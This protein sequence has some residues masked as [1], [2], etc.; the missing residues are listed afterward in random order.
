MGPE[1]AVLGLSGGCLG[2]CL[3]GCCCGGHLG[4][5]LV[6]DW[7]TMGGDRRPPPKIIYPN[8]SP[9]GP[10]K[11]LA[12]SPPDSRADS[13]QTAPRQP[14]QAPFTKTQCQ[15]LTHSGRFGEHRGGTRGP[16]HASHT[17]W[18][19]CGQR[20]GSWQR[21]WAGSGGCRLRNWKALHSDRKRPFYTPCRPGDPRGS[22]DFHGFCRIWG[23]QHL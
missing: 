13:P 18:L 7:D 9:D 2:G 8:H 23:S 17:A 1:R 15:P 14:A 6:D 5:D 4:N 3:R 11:C 10:H 22:M 21:Q 16:T 12:N 19:C 20:R